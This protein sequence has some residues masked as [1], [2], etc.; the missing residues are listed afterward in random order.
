MWVGESRF[1]VR[2]RDR[3]PG[4]A[5]APVGPARG[6]TLSIADTPP[7]VNANVRVLLRKMVDIRDLQLSPRRA[8]PC[9]MTPRDPPDSPNPSGPDY[10]PQTPAQGSENPR[11]PAPQPETPPP[12]KPAPNPEDGVPLAPGVRVPP[13][14]ITIA[15]ARSSGP[16]GQNVNKRATKCQLRITLNDIPLPEPARKRLAT[17]AGSSLTDAGEILIQDDST[18]SAHRNRQACMDRLRELVVRAQVAPKKRRPTKPGRGAIERRIDEKKRRGQ[19][20][21]RRKPPEH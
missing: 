6:A 9:R 2:P 3:G 17:L 19:A 16:G 7:R 8:M 15:F 13:G 4:G 18:R 21:Q 12:H 11:A 14:A 1:V 20:K 10:P 5:H